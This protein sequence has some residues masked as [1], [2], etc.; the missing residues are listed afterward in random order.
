MPTKVWPLHPLCKLSEITS[1]KFAMRGK[2]SNILVALA[3]QHVK[4]KPLV[5]PPRLQANRGPSHQVSYACNARLWC[6]LS[7]RMAATFARCT[8]SRAKA[9]R[10][11]GHRVKAPAS[12]D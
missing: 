5:R 2:N 12:Q 11:G 4:K 6:L 10:L 3:T 1:D 9:V 7:N 8:P